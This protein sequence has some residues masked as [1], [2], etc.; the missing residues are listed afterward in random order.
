MNRKYK[1][2]SF[3]IIFVSLFLYVIDVYADY[4]ATV[5]NPKDARCPIT[6][7]TGLCFYNDKNLSTVKDIASLDTGDIVTVLT[8]YDKIST[9]NTSLCS[10]YYVYTS[11]YFSATNKSYNGYY[12]N[13]NLSTN[14]LTNELKQVFKNKGFPESYW[15]QLSILK[16]A[17]PS[18]DFV[19]VNTSLNFNDVVNG[20]NVVKRSLVEKSASNNYAYFDSDEISFDYYNDHFNERDRIGSS[21]PWC[22]ANKETIAYYIDPRNFLSDMYIFQF[23]GLA[24][25]KSITDDTYKNIVGEIFK[26]DYL[27]KFTNDFVTAGKESGVSPVYLASLSKQEVGVGENANTAVAGTYNGMYNFYNIGATGDSNPVINGLDF[28]ANNDPS[29]LRPWNS[30]YKAI[31]GGAIWMGD[32]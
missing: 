27:S 31:V 19:A 7:T 8:N 24:F 5:I 12:C 2:L 4:K 13:A 6:N 23:E 32:K 22:D 20:E 28:A 21:N 17:H 15:E 18:W 25:D 26:N 14:A 16:T 29:T 3:L 1:Y 9:K 10:D 30:E 11:F